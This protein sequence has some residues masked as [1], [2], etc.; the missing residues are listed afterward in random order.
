MYNYRTGLIINIFLFSRHIS[1]SKSEEISFSE[2]HSC[3]I[4]FIS[5][6]DKGISLW[7]RKSLGNFTIPLSETK[8]VLFCSC[9]RFHYL[10]LHSPAVVL[11]NA[12]LDEEARRGLSSRRQSI[13]PS[14]RRLV[15]SSQADRIR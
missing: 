8:T 9:A 13:K 14:T 3:F 10:S 2:H 7:S 6:S 4:S 1:C 15:S 11:P 5:F 12:L